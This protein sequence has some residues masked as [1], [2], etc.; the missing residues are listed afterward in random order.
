MA[1]RVNNDFSRMKP[2]SRETATEISGEVAP[3][4]KP[5]VKGQ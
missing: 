1:P 2:K 3:S 4:H 5:K